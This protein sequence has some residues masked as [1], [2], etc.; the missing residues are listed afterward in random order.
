VV[1]TGRWAEGKFASLTAQQSKRLDGGL[2]ALEL[3]LVA[4]NAME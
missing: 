4:M 1:E 3:V 2:L